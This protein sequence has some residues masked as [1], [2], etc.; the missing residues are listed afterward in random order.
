MNMKRKLLGEILTEKGIIT[1]STLQRTLAR[2]KRLDKR[3]GAMLEESEL[4]TG[5]ELASALAIQYNCRVVEDFAR[6]PFTPELLRLIPADIAMENMLFPLKIEGNKL[7]LAMADPT[8]TRI[9]S[10]LAANN[11]L[12]VVPFI[13]TRKDITAAICRHYLKKDLTS[14]QEKTILVAEED[15]LLCT[16][17]GHLLSKEG[18]R[19][20]TASEGMEA[21]KMAISENPTVIVI[22]KSIP[23]LDGYGFFTALKNL[24]EKRFTPVIL[25]T[26]NTDPEEEARAFEKGF[27]DFLT[28]PVKDVTLTTRVKRAFQFYEREFGLL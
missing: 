4:I 17:L 15:S 3:L 1:K 26:A 16:M 6:H 5:E 28:K 9:V 10:N 22:D 25:M 24:P 2:A 12:K 7:A 23:K 13:A 27:F 8:N 19:V 21:Y 14:S 20:V 11:G 18:Y